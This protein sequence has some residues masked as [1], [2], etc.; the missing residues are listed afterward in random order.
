MGFAM[1]RWIIFVSLVIF[2]SIPAVSGAAAG[3]LF[4]SGKATVLDLPLF[5]IPFG[6]N[7]DS[8]ADKEKK[9]GEEA[10]NDATK[11]KEKQEKKVDD[12]LKKAWGQ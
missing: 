4:D 10:K 12:A 8:K 6:S 2:L 5:K 11:E 3:D 9:E 7:L 1:K